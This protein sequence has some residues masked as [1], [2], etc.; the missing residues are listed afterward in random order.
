VFIYAPVVGDGVCRNLLM[1][2]RNNGYSRLFEMF[3]LSADGMP[4][5]EAV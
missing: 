5:V 4:P 1:E 2:N 3:E